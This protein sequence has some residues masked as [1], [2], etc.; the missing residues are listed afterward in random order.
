MRATHLIAALLGCLALAVAAVQSGALNGRMPDDLGVRDGGRLKPPALTPNS[1]SSQARLYPQHPMQDQAMVDPLPLRGD[2]QAG[3]ERLAEA[4]AATPGATIVRREPGYL[5]VTYTTRWLK[6][7][8]DA[9][10]LLAP[11]DGVIHV[12]SASRLGRSDL[13]VNRQRI[14]ALRQRLQGG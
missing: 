4:I 2:P 6:F 1:V 5:Q 3:F 14:E 12:R 11:E 10:F 8:D 7:V 13:G 9:E